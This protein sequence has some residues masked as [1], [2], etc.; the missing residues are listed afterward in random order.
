MRVGAIFPQTEIGVDPSQ[1]RRYAQAVEDLGYDQILAYDHVL[2]ANTAS[3]PNWQGSYTQASQFHEPFVLFGYLA[4][5]TQRLEL[6]TGI[7]ILPQRQTALVAKQ[8]AAVDVL[9]GGRMR[10][11][12]GVG[13]NPVEYQGLNENFH[14]RGA[15][16]DEQIAALRALWSDTAITFNGRWHTIEDAGINPLPVRR[17]IPIWMGGHSDAA[18]KRTARLGDGWLPQ[19]RPDDESRAQVERLRAYTRAAGRPESAVAIEARLSLSLVPEDDWHT[20]VDAWQAIGATH[21][22]VNTMGLRL[23]TVEAHIE[24]LR[25]VKAVLDS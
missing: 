18:I 21:L 15:R 2:G 23:P 11:G 5:V 4:A 20:Y 12:I 13:W 9:S 25:Q 1:I 3:R 22:T 6:V 17:T 10:L 19:R 16:M 7:L 14:T 24:R 8:A